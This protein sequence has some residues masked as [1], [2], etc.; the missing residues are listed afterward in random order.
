MRYL[1]LALIMAYLTACC[2]VPLAPNP[3]HKPPLP[4]GQPYPRVAPYKWSEV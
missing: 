3:L 4:L 1:L 2:I